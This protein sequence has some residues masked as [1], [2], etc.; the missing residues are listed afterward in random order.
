[1]NDDPRVDTN[2]LP[3]LSLCS[4]VVKNKFTR[5]LNIIMFHFNL[6]LPG[7]GLVG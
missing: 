4:L 3:V 2:A 1:M 6:K 7:F 5:L